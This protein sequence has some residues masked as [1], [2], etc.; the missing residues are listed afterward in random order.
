[1]TLYIGGVSVDLTHVNVQGGEVTAVDNS[2][3]QFWIMDT[4]NKEYFVQIAIAPGDTE[5]ATIEV[6]NSE[7][8]QSLIQLG[9]W[10]TAVLQTLH[11]LIPRLSSPSL[12]QITFGPTGGFASVATLSTK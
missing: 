11:F 4:K 3:N 12:I 10:S 1:M 9:S 8:G 2:V 6:M 7:T 5:K